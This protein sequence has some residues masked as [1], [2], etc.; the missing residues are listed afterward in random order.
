MNR[1]RITE[2]VLIEKYRYDG[3]AGIES[4]LIPADA[5]ITSDTLSSDV[6]DLFNKYGMDNIDKWNA[7]SRIISDASIK[8]GFHEKK[9]T[10]ITG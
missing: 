7:I 1:R 8:K 5:F 2:D 9:K 3:I 10:I 4:Y 6:I